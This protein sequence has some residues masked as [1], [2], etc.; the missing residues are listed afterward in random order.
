MFLEPKDFKEIFGVE[1][2][3]RK[4]KKLPVVKITNPHNG[5]HVHRLFRTSHEIRGFKEYAGVTYTTIKQITDN[6]EELDTLESVLLSKGCIIPF[7]WNHPI[8]ATQMAI[9]IGVYSLVIGLISI[10]LTLILS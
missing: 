2:G 1:D 9:H 8:H 5:K 3:D 6:K 4:I 7:Y 10:V